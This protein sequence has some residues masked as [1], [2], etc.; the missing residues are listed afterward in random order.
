[1][2]HVEFRERTMTER[3]WCALYLVLRLQEQIVLYGASALD[4]FLSAMASTGRAR[5]E[6]SE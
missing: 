4:T 5:S 3:D 1:M 2:R 6:E